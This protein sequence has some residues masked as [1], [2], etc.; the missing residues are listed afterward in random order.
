MKHD[1]VIS[2]VEFNNLIQGLKLHH[3]APN[4]EGR[5]YHPGDVAVFR[6]RNSGSRIERTI[7]YI[8]SAEH[9]CALSDQALQTGFSI[10]SLSADL[11]PA[12]QEQDDKN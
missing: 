4:P 11:Q 7:S 12:H 3:L 2:S 9:P 10:L 6:D 5:P 8:T 1:F